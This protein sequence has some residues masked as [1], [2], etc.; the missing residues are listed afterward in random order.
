MLCNCE[1]PFLVS[2]QSHSA[3]PGVKEPYISCTFTVGSGS[4][5]DS[6]RRDFLSAAA[7]LLVG[8]GLPS[9]GVTEGGQQDIGEQQ[10]SV[11]LVYSSDVSE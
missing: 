6:S 2:V 5:A 9:T 11:H 1:P 7:A 8:L 3:T 10:N 4:L